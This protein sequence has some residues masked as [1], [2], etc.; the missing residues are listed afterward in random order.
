MTLA[1]FA[2]SA[3]SLLPPLV[4]VTLAILTRRVLLS[5][6]VSILLGALLLTGASLGTTAQYLGQLGLGLVWDDGALNSWNMNIIGFLLILGVLISLM[7]L[8][9]GTRAF[10]EWASARI[11]SRRQAKIL[12]GLLVF[13]FFIDDYF[14]SLAAGTVCRPITDRFNISRAK[15]AYIL[16]STAAPICVLMPISSWGAYIIAL[17]GGLLVTHQV[18]DTTA[19]WA[20]VQMVPMN[21][22]AL[23]TLAL[24][25]A[26]VVLQVDLFGMRKHE[27][28]ALRGEMLAKAATPRDDSSYR[29]QVIDLLLPI[30]VLVAATVFF[31]FQSGAASLAESGT[32]FSVLGALENTDVGAALVNG[33]LCALATAALMALRLKISV[34][35]WLKMVAQ[36][37]AVMRPAILILL[38]AWAI[39][40]VIKDLETGKYLAGLIADSLPVALLPALVFALAAFMAFSTGTSWGTFGILLPLAADLVMV[41]EPGLLL[42]VL[43]AVLAGAVC[44]DHCS[45]ISDTTILSSTGAGCNHLDHVLTQMPYALMVALISVV[46][47]LVLGITGSTLAGLGAGALLFA[48]LVVYLISLRKQQQAPSPELA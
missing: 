30:A 43:S 21:L 34:G 29:G 37:I 13:L 1:S 9:G 31:M 40:A 46:G 18:T 4:A 22:Y 27:E 11:Q 10:A 32:A 17:I 42:P 7:T 3:W 15:L 2:D 39:A 33:G 38:L 47:Y 19:F 45:P 36:G 48:G 14:H 12:T 26:V 6:G 35:H 41:A 24:V 5:L 28:A 16:D 25:V 8:T 23:F 20:F 44:G